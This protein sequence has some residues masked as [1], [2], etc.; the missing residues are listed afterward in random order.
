[1]WRRLGWLLWL[2]GWVP[3]A[4]ADVYKY[5]DANGRVYYADERKHPGYR[6]II[7]TPR[8]RPASG[9]GML[10]RRR[11]RFAPLIEQVAKKYAL[12]PRLLHAV[13][14]AESAYDP[15][16]VSPKGAVGLMQL[17]PRTARRYGIDDPRDPKANLEAGARYLRDLLRRF[18]DVRLAVAAYNAGEA[19]VEKYGNRIPPYRETRRYVARVMQFYGS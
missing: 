18:K 11:S 7:R 16:A 9:G 14:R 10:P 17:L 2:T 19:A 15:K 8:P 6:L 3:V 5:V 12:D 13:I 4:G 1:M